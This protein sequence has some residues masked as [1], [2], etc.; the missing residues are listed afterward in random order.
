MKAAE[1]TTSG[2]LVSLW[3][4]LKTMMQATR[5]YLAATVDARVAVVMHKGQ[6]SIDN[7]KKSQR[8]FAR[9]DTCCTSIHREA[10]F[11]IPN[12]S[13]PIQS[14]QSYPCEIHSDVLRSLPKG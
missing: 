7:S 5:A 12:Q 2:I 6:F 4:W 3:Q 11:A 8:E 1:Q 14:Q 13:F 10:P 9:F